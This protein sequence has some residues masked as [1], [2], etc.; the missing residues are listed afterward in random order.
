MHK[1]K[2]KS[3]EHCKNMGLVRKGH[4]FNVGNKYKINIVV[5]PYCN[6]KGSKSM[7]TRYHF[8]NCKLKGLVSAADLQ[9]Y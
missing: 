7:L 2:K 6:L 8:N 9:A 5:C 1:G 4:K 3:V